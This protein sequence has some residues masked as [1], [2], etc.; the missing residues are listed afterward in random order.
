MIV[1]HVSLYYIAYIN[2]YVPVICRK[3]AAGYLC[4][5]GSSSAGQV[6]GAPRTND[7]PIDWVSSD[8]AVF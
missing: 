2:E 5:R 7:M 3:S 1:L 8:N 4:R 6:Q